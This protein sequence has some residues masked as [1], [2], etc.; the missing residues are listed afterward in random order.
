M[1][2]L[3]GTVSTALMMGVML[4]AL[5]GCQKNEVPAE[6]AGKVVDQAVKKC[7]LYE[8]LVDCLTPG[9]RRSGLDHAGDGVNAESQHRNVEDK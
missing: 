8:H 1:M 3:G 2:K 5:S 6:R 9:G 4:G 7:S